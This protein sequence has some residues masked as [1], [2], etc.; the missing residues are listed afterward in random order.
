MHCPS[1]SPSGKNTPLSEQ[2]KETHSSN[3]E[4]HSRPSQE[5]E[6]KGKIII[7]II[8]TGQFISWRIF[9]NS[10]VSPSYLDLLQHVHVEGIGSFQ[11]MVFFM[12]LVIGFL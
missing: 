1:F 8:I 2:N 12:I 6:A 4:T 3:G 9:S 10:Q 11:W 5:E 7:I